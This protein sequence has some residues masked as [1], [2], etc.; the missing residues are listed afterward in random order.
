MRSVTRPRSPHPARTHVRSHL[1]ARSTRQR[2]P[3]RRPHLHIQPSALGLACAHASM[4]GCDTHRGGHRWRWHCMKRSD[5]TTLRGGRTACRV[6]VWPCGLHRICT[7]ESPCADMARRYARRHSIQRPFKAVH[8]LSVR[9]RRRYAV[10]VPPA[11]MS[12]SLGPARSQ[13]EAPLPRVA[14]HG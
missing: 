14:I 6:G 9:A 10:G 11:T 13:H 12:P 5:T 4:R 8:A 1:S 3:G 2:R 7:V